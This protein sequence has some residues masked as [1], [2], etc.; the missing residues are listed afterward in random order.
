MDT[1]NMVF[2]QESVICSGNNQGQ[3]RQGSPTDHPTRDENKQITWAMRGLAEAQ[4]R[5]SSTPRS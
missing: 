5:Y 2:G 3:H 1:S 4:P